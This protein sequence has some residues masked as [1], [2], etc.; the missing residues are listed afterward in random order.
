MSTFYFA[1]RGRNEQDGKLMQRVFEELGIYR[2]EKKKNV[3]LRLLGYTQPWAVSYRA[4]SQQPLRF[5]YHS[6]ICTLACNL[7]VPGV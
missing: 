7:T 2:F 1:Y 4:I 3:R 5:L 6:E